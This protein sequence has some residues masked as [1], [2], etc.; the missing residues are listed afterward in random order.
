MR[1]DQKPFSD[2]RV[3]HAMSLAIDRQAIIDSAYEGVGAVNPP[4]PA[5][6][7]EWS[8]PL[9]KLGEGAKL[10][11]HDPAG[12]KRLLAAAGY[13]NGF[14]GT[15]CFTTY[16]SPVL[17]DIM[18]LVQKDLKAVG[19]DVKIDQKERLHRDLLLRQV[20]LDDLRPADGIPRT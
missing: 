11:K 20:R 10:Y 18:Q 8:I 6:L 2:V 13:P 14:P 1:T 17:V 7:K 19:I 9:D 3:R 4:L 15:I 16:G 5:A 12:A